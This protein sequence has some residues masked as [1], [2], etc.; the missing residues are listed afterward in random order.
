MTKRRR[1]ERL[2][3]F[4]LYAGYASFMLC[5]NTLNAVSG[6]MIQDTTLGL[7]KASYGRLI[8]FNS[9][10]AIAGK[11]VTGVGADILGGRRMFLL[12]L[13]LTAA[14]TAAF[15][16]VSAFALLAFLN[17]MGMFFKAGGWP[18]MTK[19]VGN[20][21][22]AQRHGTVWAILSTSS[23]AG[24]IA[25]G[26]VLGSLLVRLTWRQV[27]FVSGGLTILI[28]AMVVAVLLK[29]R[30]EDVGLD[31]VLKIVSSDDSNADHESVSPAAHPF[32]GLTTQ[33]A[34]SRFS[35]SA[36]FWCIGLGMAFLTMM[37]DVIYLLPIYLQETLGLE[38][39]R[40]AAAGSAFPVGSFFALLIAGP[41]YDRL[42]KRSHVGFFGA[43]L[44]LAA[45]CIVF[46]Q[47]LPA[48]D[49][50]PSARHAAAIGS[51]FVFGVAVSPAYYLPM[52]IFSVSFG[53]PHSGFLVALLDIFGYLGAFV[54]N[55]F[56]GAIAQEYGWTICLRVLL[57]I[58]LAAAVL[59]TAFLMM[60]AKA[61][62]E[63]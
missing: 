53:G 9:I 7:D 58:T 49:F 60:D 29:E 35:M 48:L 10:G 1:W 8:S 41:I 11:M 59:T 6:A 2:V 44:A 61:A 40:A 25:A 30:P 55:F 24:T 12:A 47:Y 26:L 52:S 16:L 13:S 36:R 19:I 54:F 23:R 33:Q 51:L 14:S 50:S 62:A 15:G 46:L 18:A 28:T 63:A 56:G 57:G 37:M 4:A 17:F 22:P 39:A 21:Y 43:S 42:S 3:L 34:L 45:L 31:P 38:P 32:E 20:W 5:R 27:F